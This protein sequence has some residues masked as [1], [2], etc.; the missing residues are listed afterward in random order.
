MAPYQIVATALRLFAIWLVVDAV[1]TVPGFIRELRR[2]DDGAALAIS[3]GVAGLVI[4]V[5]LVLWF[6]PRTVARILVPGIATS[7]PVASSPN[8]WF[9]VGCSLIGLWLLTVTIPG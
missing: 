8:D 6:F 2:Y 3:L 9:A 7:E 1:R 4:A 5:V